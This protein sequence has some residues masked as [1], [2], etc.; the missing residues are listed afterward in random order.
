MGNFEIPENPEYTEDIRK[1]IIMLIRGMEE[2]LK[3]QT[4]DM[5]IYSMKQSG[6]W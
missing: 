4:R 3:R 6:L 5:R 1:F 2:D